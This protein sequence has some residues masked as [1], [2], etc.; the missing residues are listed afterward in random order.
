MHR[1]PRR[2]KAAESVSPALCMTAIRVDGSAPVRKTGRRWPP[3]RPKLGTAAA[4]A[5][6][7]S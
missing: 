5:A 1:P 7:A 3:P 2:A 4:S 6:K